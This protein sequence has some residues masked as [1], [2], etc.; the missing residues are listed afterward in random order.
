MAK[1][2]VDHALNFDILRKVFLSK[3]V[4]ILLVYGKIKRVFSLPHKDRG[5]L[6]VLSISKDVLGLRLLFV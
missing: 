6:S 4:R 2:K 1:I 5:D 3:F